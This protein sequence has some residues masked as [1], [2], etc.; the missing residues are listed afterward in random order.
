[1]RRTLQDYS[2]S[3]GQKIDADAVCV[4]CG[5]VNPEGTLICKTCGNNLRDQKRLRMQ[6]EEQLL[7]GD[8]LPSPRNI[9][10]GIIAILGTIVIIFAGLNADQIMMW[11]VSSS[12]FSFSSESPWSGNLGKQL[13]TMAENLKSQVVASNQIY[14]AIQKPLNIETM[15]GT[16]VIAVRDVDDNYAPVG[17]ALVRSQ[18]D[19]AYLFVALLDN[20]AQVRGVAQKQEQRLVAYWD[21]ASC[22]WGGNRGAVSGIVSKREDGHFEG[23][24]GSELTSENFGFYAFRLP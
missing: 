14:E 8:E 18:Q 17:K 12:E 20:G 7:V 4:Q 24:G 3:P 19:D 2:S 16:F 13:N 10:L 5:T 9:V 23:Y 1:M 21:R 15:E 11:L 22:E 6:A